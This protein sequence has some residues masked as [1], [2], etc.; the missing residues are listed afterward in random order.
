MN[1]TVSILRID[2]WFGARGLFG[3]AAGIAIYFGVDLFVQS[4]AVFFAAVA[5]AWFVGGF[6]GKALLACAFGLL[7]GIVVVSAT[8]PNVLFRG[9]EVVSKLGMWF[10]YCLV[11]GAVKLSVESVTKQKPLPRGNRNLVDI[12]P[13]ATRSKLD[14][15]IVPV[16][17]RIQQSNARNPSPTIRKRT[18]EKSFRTTTTRPATTSL[19]Q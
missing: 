10:F 2:E 7:V 9:E 5:V 13:T 16:K 8:N 15:S 6:P 12:L 18:H 19:V 14:N 3:L 1:Q 4:E 11:I 17:P